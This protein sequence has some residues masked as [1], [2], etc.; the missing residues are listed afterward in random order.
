MH[1][2]GQVTTFVIIGVIII[3]LVALAL[4]FRFSP[5]LA[6]GTESSSNVQEF[7]ESCID[8]V[9]RDALKHIGFQGGYNTVPADAQPIPQNSDVNGEYN[10]AHWMYGSEDH[11]PSYDRMRDE[12]TSYFNEHF[13]E[14]TNDYESFTSNGWIVSADQPM[15]LNITFDS[16]QTTFVATYPLSARKGEERVDIETF[17]PVTIPW[18]VRGIVDTARTAARLYGNNR[19]IPVSYVKEQGYGFYTANAGDG[20]I[21]FRLSSQQNDEERKYVWIFAAK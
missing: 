6:P 19:Q 12:L 3:V 8:T 20:S 9:G 2:R 5:R 17:N 21:I 16:G 7:T 1:K 13:S 4:F 10:I 15:A 11:I 18:D 14:C